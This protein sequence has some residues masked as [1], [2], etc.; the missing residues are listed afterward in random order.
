ML[1]LR[2]GQALDDDDNKFGF[3]YPVEKLDLV[4]TETYDAIIASWTDI[5]NQLP[6]KQ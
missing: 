1:E 5:S 3:V 6:W 4:Q 2:P